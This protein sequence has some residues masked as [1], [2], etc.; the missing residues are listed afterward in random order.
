MRMQMDACLKKEQIGTLF[1]GV[2][3]LE[4]G[5]GGGGGSGFV[6]PKG[7]TCHPTKKNSC[8]IPT[9]RHNS[10]KGRATYAPKANI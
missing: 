6:H 5:F 7:Y 8:C 2:G 4:R 10:N 3:A 9:N 1:V